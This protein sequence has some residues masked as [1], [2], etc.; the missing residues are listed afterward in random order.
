MPA[1]GLPCGSGARAVGP[2]AQNRDVPGDGVKRRAELD[3]DDFITS[4]GYHNMRVAISYSGAWR[5][6]GATPWKSPAIGN[7]TATAKVQIR[8]AAFRRQY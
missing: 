8:V 3:A 6:D 1:C 5:C 2:V 7:S 4:L